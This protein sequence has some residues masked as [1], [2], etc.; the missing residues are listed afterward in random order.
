MAAPDDLLP[1]PAR[2]EAA[3]GRAHPLNRRGV[4]HVVAFLLALAVAWL[5][6]RA[7]RQPGFILDF[8]NFLLC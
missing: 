2:G 4:W 1:D 5:V 8:A 7:Y 6:A 3:A